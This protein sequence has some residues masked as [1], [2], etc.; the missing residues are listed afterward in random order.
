MGGGWWAVG[1]GGGGVVGG[2]GWWWWWWVVGWGLWVWVVGGGWRVVGG[3]GWWLVVGGGCGCGCGGGGPLSGGFRY[4]V[5]PVRS[6]RPQDLDVGARSPF[7]GRPRRPWAGRASRGNAPLRRGRGGR[8][9]T[10]PLIAAFL[11]PSV[12]VRATSACDV[13]LPS[14]WRSPRGFAPSPPTGS[15][16]PPCSW[17]QRGRRWP[18]G[19]GGLRPIWTPPRGGGAP[20]W[21]VSSC[22]ARRRAPRAPH[23]PFLHVAFRP[24]QAACD[25][26]GTTSSRCAPVMDPQM[27]SLDGRSVSEDLYSR[28]F[29]IKHEAPA[30]TKQLQGARVDVFPDTVMGASAQSV[31]SSFR[32]RG[33]ASCGV[34]SKGPLAFH[35]PR[36]APA[37]RSARGRTVFVLFAHS[38]AGAVS[39][40]CR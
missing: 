32:N 31:L 1:G 15:S 33:C 2:G 28:H 16:S 13:L 7:G 14:A 39:L 8:C 30:G 3:G 35:W 18:A 11:R 24:S 36:H 27:G 12:G 40:S 4:G 38:T 20:Q 29:S 6:C 9:P 25:A 26:R 22:R 10:S 19:G 37:Q 17:R 21:F 5:V 34:L 23:L